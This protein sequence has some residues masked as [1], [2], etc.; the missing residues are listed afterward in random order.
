MKVLAVGRDLALIESLIKQE[1]MEIVTEHPDVIVT[2]GGDGYLLDAER[3]YPGVP[4]LAIRH[5]SICKNCVDHETSHL[6]KM[7]AKDQLE[8]SSVTKLE[9]T[10][11]GKRYVV[12]NEFSLHHI[13]P[14]QAIRF[15]VRI[16]NE[17]R[18]EQAIGDGVIIATPFGS[19]AYYRSITNST[20]RLGIGIAYNNTTEPVDHMVIRD[21]DVVTIR[22]ARG[23]AYLLADNDPNYITVEAEQIITIRRS[24][25]EAVLLGLEHI[26]CPD[27]GEIESSIKSFD[28]PYDKDG[29]RGLEGKI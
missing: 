20:F 24:E 17:K 12:L 8:A 25:Q 19:H 9:T 14:H 29:K 5:N 28:T 21:T 1:G 4:K 7:L 26:H 27:C 16:N 6:I 18:E 2:H 22:I 15:S 23:P 3:I 10:I 13:K 11:N